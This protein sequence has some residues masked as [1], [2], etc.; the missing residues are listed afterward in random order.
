MNE[1]GDI[2]TRTI[3]TIALVIAVAASILAWMAF[4]RTGSNLDSRIQSQ[5]NQAA[6]GMKS[7]L[8]GTATDDGAEKMSPSQN[9][10]NSGAE[11]VPQT[12]P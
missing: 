10:S 8:Q 1:R 12:Q 5:V 3:A 11:T 9:I 2:A 7:T 4:D 6:Q